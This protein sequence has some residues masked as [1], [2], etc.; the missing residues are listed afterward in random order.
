M[1][2]PI[3]SHPIGRSA[4]LPDSATPRERLGA[5][6]QQLQSVFVEQLFK[7][8]RATVPDDGLFSGGSGEETFRSLLD[9]RVAELVPA[10]WHGEHTLGAALVRQLARA[11]P[12][13]S[14]AAPTP[15]PSP[16][17]ENPS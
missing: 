9:Q 17:A 7:A 4:R 15:S 12:P 6:A 8:M 13:E 14:A 2:G 11:L 1:S 16:R 10:Q 5:T 3:T